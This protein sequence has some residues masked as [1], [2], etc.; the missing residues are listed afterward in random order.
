MQA[1]LLEF[2]MCDSSLTWCEVAKNP[3]TPQFLSFEIFAKEAEHQV[4][5][6]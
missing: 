1:S 4:V 2:I 5:T 3:K 6:P